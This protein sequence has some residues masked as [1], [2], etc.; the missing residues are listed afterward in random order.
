M[1]ARAE[2]RELV[3]TLYADESTPIDQRSARALGARFGVSKRTIL[4]D[5]HAAGVELRPAHR[6]P[7]GDLT[8]EERRRRVAELYA[9]MT[10]AEIA[11]DL[12]CSD[13]TIKRDIHE[14]GLEVR[15][16]AP[17]RQ[18]PEPQPR[19]CEFCSIDFTPTAQ[20]L[21]NGYGRWCTR[22][23]WRADQV[24]AI[25]VRAIET[26]L[27]YEADGLGEELAAAHGV[28]RDTVW[29]DL[30]RVG[31]LLRGRPRR[32][33]RTVVCEC[34]CGK[35]RWVYSSQPTRFVGGSAHWARHRS[36]R[37]WETLEGLVRS[38]WDWWRGSARRRW[39]NRF[40][41]KLERRKRYSGEQ[42]YRARELLGRGRSIRATAIATG[43]T[44][45]Q[46]ERLKRQLSA[47]AKVSP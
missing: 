23:C 34:G 35:T 44:K 11:A 20:Q 42:G 36:E 10:C 25:D 7:G 43:L 1:L 6:L 16:A 40:N 12:G 31:A 3:V 13:Q 21:T 47:A 46:V 2:R 39:K 9:T 4:N 5:L 17:R 14:L 41:S 33:G 30:R 27:A 37:C 8:I 45:K 22:L 28:S 26:V 24:F 19:P 15:P 18:H 38:Q 32:R 29:R